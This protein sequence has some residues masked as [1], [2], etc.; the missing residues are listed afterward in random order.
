MN[1][2]NAMKALL[3][4]EKITCED[5]YYKDRYIYLNEQGNIVT[6]T[7][8][9]FEHMNTKA[10]WRTYKSTHLDDEEREYLKNIIEPY[11]DRIFSIE[12]ST[13]DSKPGTYHIV[14]ILANYDNS[15]EDIITLPIFP[16]KT[17]MYKGLSNGTKYTLKDLD[18]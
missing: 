8:G 18:L 16:Y 14:I 11:R 4:G 6:N 10:V 5:W 17:N 13:F 2:K 12:K 15:G 7:G 9:K 3:N 1:I